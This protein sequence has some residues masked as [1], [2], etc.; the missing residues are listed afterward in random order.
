VGNGEKYSKMALKGGKLRKIAEPHTKLVEGLRPP[1]AILD[2]ENPH[3]GIY[4]LIEYNMA[5]CLILV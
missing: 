3:N 5:T 2:F 1:V 4:Q